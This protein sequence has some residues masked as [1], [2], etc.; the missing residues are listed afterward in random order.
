MWVKGVKLGA[1]F[2]ANTEGVSADT[3]EISD[4][5]VVAGTGVVADSGVEDAG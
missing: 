1:G 2:V 4:T 3:M 5:V